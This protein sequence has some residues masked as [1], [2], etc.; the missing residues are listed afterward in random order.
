MRDL[1][2]YGESLDFLFLA[3]KMMTNSLSNLSLEAP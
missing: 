3:A 1:L 2:F